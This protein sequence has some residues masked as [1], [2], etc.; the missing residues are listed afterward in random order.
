VTPR[1]LTEADIAAT[2][3]MPAA[4]RAIEDGL[5]Q[6]AAGSAYAMRKTYASWD[7]ATLHAIGGVL[8]GEGLAGTKT[9]AHTP[10]GA[11]P[12]VLL[13]DASDGSLRALIEAFTLGQLRTGAVCGVATSLVSEPDADEL[14]II[15]AGKQALTQVAAVAAVRSLRRVRV[16]SRDKSKASAFCQR[17]TD[18]LAI[19]ATAADS[20]AE[21]VR[22][23]PIITLSTRATEP[24]LSVAMPA[25][26]AHINAIG[27][28]TP[29]RIEFD[30][31]LLRRCSVVAVDSVEQ[32]RE[33]SS[34]FRSFYGP[35]PA[36]WSTVARLA[37]LVASDEPRP[38]AA[39][40]TLFKATGV[41]LFDLVLSANCLR[42]A[43]EHDL[44]L[45]LPGPIHP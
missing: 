10:G 12:Y 28:I 15:G 14:A 40:L 8:T 27:A 23:A 42:H 36:A 11:A 7:G 43:E 1:L 9:W 45:P 41:G 22:D 38:A 31:G 32:A 29:E 37:D 33:L 35:D 21:A 34:E 16:Y 3:D 17:V 13:F 18:Q 19:P 20:V 24:F 44:G 26:G 6:Q 4:I 2:L 39:D 30:P 5:R 25:A